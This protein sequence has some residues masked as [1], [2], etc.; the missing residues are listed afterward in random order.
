MEHEKDRGEAIAKLAE[1]IK[2]IKIAMLTTVDEEGVLHSRPMATQKEEFAGTLWFFNY[3]DSAKTR[4]VAKEHQ[5]NVSYSDP[6]HQKYVSVSGLA[7]E[8]QDKAKAEQ[9]WNPMLKA[10]FPQGLEDPNLSLLKIDVQRAEYWDSP[11]SKM[12]QLYGYLKAV[13]TGQKYEGEG[14]EHEKLTV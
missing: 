11:S 14:S 1:L 6:D 12:V 9:L 7:R 13:A 8:V 10:W 4:E 5:V 3:H 2:D